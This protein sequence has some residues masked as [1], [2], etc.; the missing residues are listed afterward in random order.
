MRLAGEG[1]GDMMAAGARQ[2]Q[3]RAYFN[4]LKSG[5]RADIVRD[6]EQADADFTRAFEARR[7]K[8]EAFAKSNFG[9]EPAAGIPDGKSLIKRMVECKDQQTLQKIL[10]ELAANDRGRAA[11]DNPFRLAD[12]YDCEARTPSLSAETVVGQLRDRSR[13]MA[14]AAKLVPA[15]RVYDSDRATFLLQAA[16]MANTAAHVENAARTLAGSVSTNALFAGRCVEKLEELNLLDID[17]QIR[18]QQVFAY[19]RSGRVPEAAEQAAKLGEQLGGDAEYQYMAAQVYAAVR[20]PDAAVKAL[21]AALKAGFSDVA[22][23]R[24]NPNFQGLLA[25]KGFKALLDV[26]VSPSVVLQLQGGFGAPTAS[27]PKR[28]VLT[29][30]N[31]SD[32]PLT[33]VKVQLDVYYNGSTV[34]GSHKD[35]AAPRINPKETVTFEGAAAGPTARTYQPKAI[36]KLAVACD[37]LP[38]AAPQRSNPPTGFK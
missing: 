7:A 19:A 37:Q 9:I 10:A 1:L 38:A 4:S 28:N 32:F 25:N 20:K 30:T 17:G 26:R 36:S 5:L 6:L 27:D 15:G 11:R 33:N 24:A 18:K 14:A 31:D 35:F 12:L 2:S 3:N 21:S 34:A 16:A 8:T 22:A 29:L 23:V 13:D